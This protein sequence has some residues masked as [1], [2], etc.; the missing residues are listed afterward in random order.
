MRCIAAIRERKTDQHF[1]LTHSALIVQYCTIYK[2]LKI[3]VLQSIDF[4]SQFEPAKIQKSLSVK[5]GNFSFSG[6]KHTAD[7]QRQ[8]GLGPGDP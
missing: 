3:K 7:Q 4:Q 6:L 2:A 5:M 8:R 1:A